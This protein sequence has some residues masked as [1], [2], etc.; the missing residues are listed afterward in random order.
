MMSPSFQMRC[1]LAFNI[2]AGDVND[3]G[4]F[5]LLDRDAFIDLLI[6]GEYC[7]RLPANGA[8]RN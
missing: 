4:S 7:P 1:S 3:D 8:R 5:N 6:S 2:P